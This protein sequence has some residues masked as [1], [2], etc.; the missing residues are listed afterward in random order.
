MSHKY[1]QYKATEVACGV[2]LPLVNS[3]IN[4]QGNSTWLLRNI[5]HFSSWDEHKSKH[6]THMLPRVYSNKSTS[7]QLP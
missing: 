5:I 3:R 2:Q 4:M 1:E 7:V 6:L